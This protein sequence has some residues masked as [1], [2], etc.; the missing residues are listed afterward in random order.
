[1]RIA[2]L[3]TG[4]VGRTIAAGLTSLGHE[5]MVGTRDPSVTRKRTE[6]DRFG[7]AIAT[8]LSEHPDI[9]LGTFAE[10]ASHGQLVVNATSGLASIPAL[11][12]AGTPHLAGKI[13]MD[14]A[15]LLDFSHGMP[16]RVQASPEASLAERIQQ[17]FPTAKVVKTLNTMSA[18]LMVDPGVLAGGDH[19][20]FISGNDAIAKAHVAELL[21]SLG[22]RDIIDLGE[23]ST[24][25]GT[26]LLLPLWLSLRHAL[27]LAPTAYQ[28]KIVR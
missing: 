17:T 13:L 15:N 25:R 2:V 3:G 9:G 8:W 27:G 19:T 18:G 5:V 12:S 6:P 22:W 20:V 14:V 4:V 21:R 23:L 16:P 24:A 10:A 26:E 28:F 7:T 11:T 1:M